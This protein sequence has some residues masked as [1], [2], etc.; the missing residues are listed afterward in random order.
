MNW[1]DSVVIDQSESQLA[2]AFLSLRLKCCFC[3]CTLCQ[4]S[5]GSRPPSR[6]PVKSRS[7][8]VLGHFVQLQVAS[9]LQEWRERFAP[10]IDPV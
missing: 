5:I 2:L 10:I 3:C 7:F 6:L 1:H 9:L 8:L 4:Q